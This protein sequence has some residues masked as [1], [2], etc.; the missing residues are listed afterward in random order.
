MNDSITLWF[1]IFLVIGLAIVW[2]I[3][4]FISADMLWFIHS[5]V[6]RLLAVIFGIMVIRSAIEQ[7]TDI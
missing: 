6:G 1:L 5:W 7:A 3:G 2:A 4:S